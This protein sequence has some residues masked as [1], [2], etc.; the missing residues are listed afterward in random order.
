MTDGRSLVKGLPIK[1]PLDDLKACS[2][3]NPEISHGQE[4]T[5]GK[6]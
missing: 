6:D 3:Y 5:P 2:L 4:D 1:Q